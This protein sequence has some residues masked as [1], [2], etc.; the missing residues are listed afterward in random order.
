MLK[1]VMLYQK[2]IKILC[3]TERIMKEIELPL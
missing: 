3:E 2:I 1:D